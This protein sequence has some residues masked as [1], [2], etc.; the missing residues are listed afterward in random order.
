MASELKE[1]AD[2]VKTA[3]SES[4]HAQSAAN[5]SL[6]AAK[7]DLDN[8]QQQLASV[9]ECFVCAVPFMCICLHMC[10]ECPCFCVRVF[11]TGL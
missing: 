2:E 10:N 3:L 1:E 7:S 8:T 11:F 9:S 6:K 4:E 5:D